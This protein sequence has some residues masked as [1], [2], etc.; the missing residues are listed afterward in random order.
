MIGSPSWQSKEGLKE[1]N[2]EAVR[3]VRAVRVAS[4]DLYIVSAKVAH[5]NR[6]SSTQVT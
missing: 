2:T 4:T 6:E 3:A 1:M 5:E